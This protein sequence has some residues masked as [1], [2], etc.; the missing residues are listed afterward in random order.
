LSAII[1]I[2]QDLT[3]KIYLTTNN[4]INGEGN[5]YERRQL[6]IAFS[7]FY[8]KDYVPVDDYGVE[9]FDEWESDQWS[10]FYNFAAECPD[11]IFQIFNSQTLQVGIIQANHTYLQI[12]FI[13]LFLN[14]VLLNYF[15]LQKCK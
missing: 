14:R 8:N 3:S 15:A 11:G 9:F 12:K 4:A 10:L 2:P 13:I 5:S 6:L 7:D 1:T